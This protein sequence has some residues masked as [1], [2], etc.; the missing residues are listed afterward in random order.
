MLQL[1]GGHAGDADEQP[2]NFTDEQPDSFTDEQPDGFA[3]HSL[4]RPTMWSGSTNVCVG[5]KRG[6]HLRPDGSARLQLRPVLQ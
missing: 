6:I 4:Q 3:D 2:D 5:K 1:A